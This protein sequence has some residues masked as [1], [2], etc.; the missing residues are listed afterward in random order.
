MKSL[1]EKLREVRL[2]HN[3]SMDELTE[4]L[5]KKYN[6]SISKSMVSRWENDKA[7]PL[8]TYL[9][10]YAKEFNQ[11]MNYLLGLD[12]KVEFLGK[13]DIMHSYKYI[14]TPV[15][16]GKPENIDGQNYQEISIPSKLLGKY[17]GNSDIIIMKV[18]GDSMNK[19][20]P[21]DSLVAILPYQSS[22]D[23]KDGDIVVFN[24]SSHD[25][26]VKRYYKVDNKIIFKPESTSP[27]FTDIVYDLESETVDI[28][29]KVI[30]YTVVI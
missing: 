30:M 8:N 13:A 4:R 20:I 2:N 26:S 18:Y 10:A 11:D 16:A 7:E 1:G 12:E 27:A 23:I 28:I 17:A 3:L 9:A 19:I 21:N 25:Y 22:L 14:P 29:G 5:N 6:L 24:D 15:A